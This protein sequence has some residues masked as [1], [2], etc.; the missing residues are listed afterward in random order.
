MA[1]TGW[2]IKSAWVFKR[3]TIAVDPGNTLRT[4]LWKDWFLS[5]SGPVS[6]AG[7]ASV[8]ASAT[9]AI[10]TQTPLEGAATAA[11]SATGSAVQ[12]T[13][14]EGAASVTASATGEVT[15]QT[16]MEGA[17]SVASDGAGAVS[18]QTAI[19][20]QAAGIVSAT[21]DLSVAAAAVSLAGAATTT[22]SAT[23]SVIVTQ[24]AFV[25]YNN[26]IILV[27]PNTV[28]TAFDYTAVAFATRM[29]YGSRAETTGK[30]YIE[31]NCGSTQEASYRF[32]F[33][34]P[35]HVRVGPFEDGTPPGD[36]AYSWGFGSNGYIY[37]NGQ[38]TNPTPISFLSSNLGVYN[39]YQFDFFNDEGILRW[40][41]DFDAGKL[42]AGYYN[43]EDNNDLWHGDPVA[44]TNPSYT[45]TPNT[46]LVPVISATY[47]NVL[48]PTAY[49]QLAANRSTMRAAPPAGFNRWEELANWAEVLADAPYGY[50]LAGPTIEGVGEI[51][52]IGLAQSEV[53]ISGNRRH[54]RFYN[55][56]SYRLRGGGVATMMPAQVAKGFRPLTFAGVPDDS[57]YSLFPISQGAASSFSVEC[58]V[59]ITGAG[60]TSSSD[61]KGGCMAFCNHFDA[62][63]AASF[64]LSDL[65]FGMSLRDRRLRF[66]VGSSE[67]VSDADLA[68]GAYHVVCVLNTTAG[69]LT[70]YIN[71]TQNAQTS[72][73]TS[74]GQS[75]VYMAV[76]S[77]RPTITSGAF[78]GYIRD[79]VYYKDTALSSTRIAAH[80]AR[81]IE[82]PRP[83]FIGL[84]TD[85]RT[86]RFPY[87]T[88]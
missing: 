47:A 49:G 53:D 78:P 21:G 50:W 12:T 36:D 69:T 37:H 83:N 15:Q 51:N 66:G 62:P 5:A 19:E 44:D 48:F 8:T 40:A 18:Q 60:L 63:A 33:V 82:A 6:L 7:S 52:S 77:T 76:G 42:W 46:P 38:A 72:G 29:F 16:E 57:E 26:P 17:A 1:E 58:S 10:G 43:Y 2:K 84:R 68:N 45:F 11:A 55:S 31:Y 14:L 27:G 39:D 54:A 79:V 81:L 35:G 13:T 23:D 80:H 24:P 34:A 59:R 67:V 3:K 9:G 4:T 86:A 30:R 20:G 22:A 88:V 25:H 73:Y 70:L 32:G 41:V 71:G 65:W 56:S 85:G 64:T 28:A 75:S 87:H 74:G 61:W